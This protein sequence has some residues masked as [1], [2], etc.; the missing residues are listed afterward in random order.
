[1]SIFAERMKKGLIEENPVFIQVLAM[2]PTLAVTSS[3]Q[4]AVGMGLAATAVLIGSNAV[5]ALLRKFIPDKIRIP[6]YITV[7]AAFVTLIQFLVQGY[8]PALYKAL[9]IFIPLIVVNCVIL[10]RAEAYASKN[11]V[12]PSVFDAIGMGLGFTLALVI[13]STFREILGNGTFYGI[14]VLPTSYEPSIIM[15]LAPGAFITLGI[16]LAC[17]NQFKINKAK[18]AKTTK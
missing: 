2:C 13:L 10:G 18:A 12:L 1:M 5:I 3:V 6:A 17:L 14:Q 7:I 8:L 16:L 4:N 9:G 15:I 11:G